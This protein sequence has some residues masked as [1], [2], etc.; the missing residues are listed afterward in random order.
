MRMRIRVTASGAAPVAT[1]WER[2]ED[3]S[4]WPTWAGHIASV[5]ADGVRLREGLQGRVSGPLGVGVAF[6]VTAVDPAARSWSWSV[7]T[8]PLRLRLDH[9]LAERPGGGTTAG[10]D[11]EG[12]AP[13]V[14]AYAPVARL[15]LGRLV[16]DG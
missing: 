1:A 10:L 8:G 14:L 3:L 13:V 2:Y 16:A 5:E 11:V 15:A 9:D 7:R 6:V 12:P 4:A